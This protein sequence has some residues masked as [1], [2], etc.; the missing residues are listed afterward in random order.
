[1]GFQRI[2]GS[3]PQGVDEVAMTGLLVRA[4]NHY[5]EST[6]CPVEWTVYDVHEEVPVNDE[7]FSRGMQRPRIDIEFTRIAP[8]RRPRFHF[9][10]KRLRNGASLA[11]YLGEDGLGCFLTERYARTEGHAGM[12]GYVESDSPSEWAEKLCRSLRRHVSTLQGDGFWDR[13]MAP[14]L[15]HCYLT[16]HA[17][18]EGS[19]PIDVYHT[20]L[21]VRRDAR[22]AGGEEGASRTRD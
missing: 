11:D 17:R 4:V 21:D 6:E 19:H 3:I 20:L 7:A 5:L 9:E 1:M 16:K 13:R 2:R 22:G 8:G 12:L 18:S 10:A 14:D 15:E